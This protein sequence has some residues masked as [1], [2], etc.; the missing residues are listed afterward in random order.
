M[1]P[2]AVWLGV[3]MAHHPWQDVHHCVEA[4]VMSSVQL[5][6][7]HEQDVHHCLILWA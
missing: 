7:A 4:A 3:E 2:R 6:L 1:R 5:I